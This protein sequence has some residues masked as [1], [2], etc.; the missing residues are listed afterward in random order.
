MNMHSYEGDRDAVY[1]YMGEWYFYAAGGY[2]SDA[3]PTQ[4]DAEIALEKFNR[5]IDGLEGRCE[6]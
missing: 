1:A 4:R 5:D 6:Q 2:R 3:F